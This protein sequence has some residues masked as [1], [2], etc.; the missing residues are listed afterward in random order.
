VYSVINIT[1]T[2]LKWCHSS[3]S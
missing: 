2:T 1:Y 3:N